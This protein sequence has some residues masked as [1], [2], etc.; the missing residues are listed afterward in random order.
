MIAKRARENN[1]EKKSEEIIAGLEAADMR[2]EGVK[3][4]LVK[5]LAEVID[6]HN[7]RS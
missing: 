3:R 6:N 2:S 5:D 1:K 7:D 4:L